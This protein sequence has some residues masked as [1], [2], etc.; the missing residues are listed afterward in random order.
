MLCR[1]SVEL[2]GGGAQSGAEVSIMLD[3]GIG[4]RK[5]LVVDGAKEHCARLTRELPRDRYSLTL[6]GSTDEAVQL[7]RD[8]AYDIALIELRIP[9]SDS[10]GLL[11]R[12]RREQP[13][14]RV[15]MMTD[16]GDEELWVDLINEGATDLVEKP[17]SIRDLE[18]AQ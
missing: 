12:I 2:Y 10:L 4:V 15:I 8:T 5:V 17:V 11:R 6:V 13:L 18:R 14:T 7:I 9:E 3:P 1:T 16:F